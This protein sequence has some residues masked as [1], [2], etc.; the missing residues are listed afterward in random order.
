MTKYIL[1]ITCAFLGASHAYASQE[2]VD[3]LFSSMYGS[4]G[5]TLPDLPYSYN[6]LEPYVDEQTMKLHHDKHHRGYVTKFNKTIEKQPLLKEM[7]LK[8]ILSN[9]ENL[10][11]DARTKQSIRD[12]GGGH[13]NHSLFWLIMTNKND[14][15][16]SP[17]VKSLIKQQW[18]S[19]D[20]FKKD[21]V[22]AAGSLFGSGWVWLCLKSDDSLTITTTPN[23]NTPLDKGLKPLI[24]LDVWEH[25]YYLKY[26]NNRSE[27]AQNWFNTINWFFVDRLYSYYTA[28]RDTQEEE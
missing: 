12:N 28:D 10:P 21:F 18:G 3:I 17:I 6:A 22:K 11:L 9:I 7:S 20:A 24:G 16:K 26:Q 19:L 14:D 15:K 8:H 25:A 1:G 5:Y 2:I 13:F 27:Y 23:Q 4:Q